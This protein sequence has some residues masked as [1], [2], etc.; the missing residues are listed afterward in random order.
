MFSG[1]VETLGIIHAILKKND[2]YYLTIRPQLHFDDLR[3]GDSVAVNGTCLTVTAITKEANGEYQF[4]VEVVPETLRLTN[5]VD[6]KKESEVN[7]ER[8]LQIGARLGGHF[9]QGH[10]DG[11]GKIVGIQSD[12]ELALLV[13]IDVPKPLMP[14]IISKGFITLDG[15]SLT[16]VSLT[17]QTMTVTLI[18]HT[19]KVTVAKHYQVG[20]KINIEVDMMSK[21][22]EKF[23]EKNILNIRENKT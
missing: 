16:I 6:C 17:E 4:D 8:S 5:L 7:L 19:Q 23:L 1:I 9:V 15:M 20:S 10:V 18:P 2:L 11:I 22:I 12:G 14:Y 13:T 21:Y 3:I